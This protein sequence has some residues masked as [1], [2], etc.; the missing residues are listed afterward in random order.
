MK[1]EFEE[2]K[3][4][5]LSGLSE[6]YKSLR[7]G[8][9][10][11]P[12]DGADDVGDVLAVIKQIEPEHRLLAD[13]E[14]KFAFASQAESAIE[15]SDYGLADAFLQASIAYA[16]DDARLKDLRYQVTTEL[17]RVE[18]EKRV[19]EIQGRL[20][21]QLAG[22]ES[23]ED[24]QQVRDDLIVLA[25]LSPTNPVLNR[26]Q[27]NL[28]Q[29]YSTAL[30]ANIAAA[31]WD[32]AEQLLVAYAKLLEVPYL[33]QKRA[34]LSK[35]EKGAG[36][37][38]ATDATRE[39]DVAQRMAE[40]DTLLSNPEFTTDWEI[41]L[42]GP[43]KE[44]IALLPFGDPLLEP[45]RN[46]TARLYLDQA[47]Q[48]REAGSFTQALAFVDKGLIFYPGLKN[49]DDE[50][51]AIAVSKAEAERRRKEEQRLSRIAS[52]KTEFEEKAGRADIAGAHEVLTELGAEALEDGD[53][54]LTETAPTVLAEA[55]LSTAAKAAESSASDAFKNALTLAE[56]GL[57]LAPENPA[58]LE[59]VA[60]YQQEVA[61]RAEVTKLG[62]LFKSKKVLTALDV[63]SLTT[64]MNSAK[65]RFPDE[66][67]AFRNGWQSDRSNALL[68]YAKDGDK[69]DVFAQ[70]VGEFEKLFPEDKGALRKKATAAFESSIRGIKPTS[71]DGLGSV[72]KRLAGFKSLSPE[73]H[74]TLTDA[75]GSDVAKSIEALIAAKK[76][77]QAGELLTVARPTFSALD[78]FLIEVEVAAL[79]RT[80]GKLTAAATEIEKAKAVN[81]AHPDIAPLERQIK[82]LMD[83]LTQQYA[84]AKALADKGN[85]SEQSKINK[86][87]A[88]VRDQ[89]RDNPKFKKIVVVALRKG[90]CTEDLAGQGAKRG[91][92]CYDVVAKKKGPR[93]VVVPA[94]G[95]LS[96]PFAIGK[97][98]VTISDY[99]L[100]CK[101]SKQCKR[102]KGS[103]KLPVTNIGI[104]QAEQ[105]ATWLS[106]EASK[107]EKVKVVYRLSTEAEWLHA[108]KADGESKGKKYTCRVAGVF[109]PP[110]QPAGSGNPNGWGLVNYIGN[111]QEWVKTGSG[112]AARGGNFEDPLAKC[113]VELSRPHSGEADPKTGFRFVRELG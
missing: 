18:N 90:S 61:N 21:Q 92:F 47:S 75:I 64:A 40:V 54:Y 38:I 24:F 73:R 102:I 36:F 44:L 37:T 103:G 89:W 111:A 39:A 30:E 78:A 35:A 98:E 7:D 52:L 31:N 107:S 60:Q 58:L 66:Y 97:F 32:G 93:L 33:T 12:I 105:Y 109:E 71:A 72:T 108:A 86:A 46:R 56:A 70:R 42:K 57:A 110:L 10:L 51:Q 2:E 45:V 65:S 4:T 94:G 59:A 50:V 104:Q 17:A 1:N 81:A 85:K 49:F 6:R 15:G 29:A 88:A 62:E 34:T 67:A 27:K 69:I 99:N 23:L 13:S 3:E 100:F 83:K 53:A 8:G 25:D 20:E 43:Y 55:Y 48:A 5:T 77:K 84:D 11:I 82:G 80:E 9:A 112:Y 22:L 91:G 101:A 79:L 14:L 95:G 96:S 63:A 76:F 74:K 28:K 106:E 41:R 16:P 19:A 68:A 26:I 113:N 87:V